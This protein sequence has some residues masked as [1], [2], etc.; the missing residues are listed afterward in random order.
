MD[1]SP[2]NWKGGASQAAEK[3]VGGVILSEAKNLCICRIRQMR[4][5]FLR[6]TQDR[7]RLLRMTV[8]AV[9]PQP[10]SA[11]PFR[12]PPKPSQRGEKL[13]L[14]FWVCCNLLRQRRLADWFAR[15]L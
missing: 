5:S 7:L 10:V 4:R 12:Q 15:K 2:R 11:P 13:G 3:L 8:L 6:F 9:F 1:F 14:A